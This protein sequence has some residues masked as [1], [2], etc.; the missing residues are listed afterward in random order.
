MIYRKNWGLLNRKD[1]KM[2]E[3]RKSRKPLLI[4]VIL[5]AILITAGLIWYFAYKVPQEK[6]HA[7]ALGK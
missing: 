4:T 7:E 6:A 1:Q 5:I 3:K 2:E